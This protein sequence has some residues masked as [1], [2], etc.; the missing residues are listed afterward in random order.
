MRK[1]SARR[2]S[3][4]AIDNRDEDV[5][6]EDEELCAIEQQKVQDEEEEEEQDDDDDDYAHVDASALRRFYARRRASEATY[7]PIGQQPGDQHTCLGRRVRFAIAIAAALNGAFQYGYHGALVGTMHNSIEALAGFADN[8]QGV[9]E[10]AVIGAL[11]IGGLVGSLSCPMMRCA[12]VLSHKL[13]KHSG[14]LQHAHRASYGPR[15]RLIWSNVVA[16]CAAPAL[17]MAQ[18]AESFGLLL[19]GRFLVGV[20]CGLAACAAPIYIDD[21]AP[22]KARRR[23]AVAYQLC[24]AFGHLVAALAGQILADDSS[25]L[26][27][28]RLQWPLVF[29]APLLMGSASALCALLICCPESPVH[30]LL[31]HLDHRQAREA[32]CLSRCYACTSFDVHK[33]AQ[34][35]SCVDAELERIRAEATQLRARLAGQLVESRWHQPLVAS[36]IIALSLQLSG[37]NAIVLLAQPLL[38]SA[39]IEEERARLASLGMVGV[40]LL[41]TSLMLF[42]VDKLDRRALFKRSIMVMTLALATLSLALAAPQASG[43]DGQ[44][45]LGAEQ[46][47]CIL[48]IYTFAAAFALGPGSLA[49]PLVADWFEP[50]AR[51]LAASITMAFGWLSNLIVS[52]SFLLAASGRVAY[53][54][55]FACFAVANLAVLVFAEWPLLGPLGDTTPGYR[56]LAAS[57]NSDD[58]N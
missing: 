53:E 23:L 7:A 54:A 17:A 9:A 10:A 43:K 6:G 11:C 1:A 4:V 18:E 24:I 45:V 14:E 35:S 21:L 15:A 5:A 8:Q 33:D 20:H 42:L 51:P 27:D 30:L 16:L 58:Y 38:R 22:R 46:V 13:Y 36:A 57:F 19:A 41:A 26:A 39:H 25:Q 32:L 44:L 50:R 34:T 40:K 12:T 47:A 48:A 2:I 3:S 37:I 55:V 52:Q 29:G 56:S 31:S 49:W 28:K